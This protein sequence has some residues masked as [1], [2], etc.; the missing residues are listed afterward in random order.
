M[1]SKSFR[2]GAIVILSIVVAAFSLLSYHGTSPIAL[3]SSPHRNAISGLEGADGKVL[4]VKIDDTSYARPQ[5]GVEE[6]DLVYIEQ[7]EGGLTRLAAVFSRSIPELIGP[8]RSARITDIDLFSQYGYI[9]FAYSGA[10]TKLRPVI[11]AA[12]W[13]DV[14]A[15][16]LG[17]SYYHNDPH[18]TAP[19]AMMMNAREVMSKLAADSEPIATAK[20]MGWHFGAAPE[21]GTEISQ[22]RVSW[23]AASYTATWSESQK[24]WL[25]S[26]SGV[27]NFAASGKELGASTF[28]IQNVVI[29]DSEY[30]DKVGGITPLSHVIGSGTGYVLR[31]GKSFP[32]RWS[33]VSAE[34]G[35]MWSD[36]HG[37]EIRFAPGQIWV[38]LTDKS[39]LFTP[40]TGSP[41]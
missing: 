3:I 38:A 19:Y 27:K 2:I 26:N 35:T 18:R 15:E 21:S 25:L 17:R 23:P 9:A 16:R 31:D 13:K 7:V 41:A 40:K 8:V 29:T 36:I 34:S 32:A 28:L 1:S 4:V 11:A 5:V 6:A 24:R 12:N 10:Q 39:P 14:G 37:K 22:V 20:N 33:R 30:R